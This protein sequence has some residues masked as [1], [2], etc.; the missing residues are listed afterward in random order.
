MFGI[1]NRFRKKAVVLMYHKIAEPQT[2]PWELAV[3]AQN[4]E[5]HSKKKK[6]KCKVVS[7]EELA[8]KVQRNKLGRRNVAITFDDAYLNNYTIAKPLLENYNLPA[9]FFI[10]DNNLVNQQPFWWDSLEQLIIH[11]PVLPQH[12]SVEFNAELIEF[13]LQEEAL[14]TDEL[15]KKH[16][17]FIAYEPNT[18]RS[19][20]YYKLW[21]FMSPL[22]KRD[23]DAFM[24]KIYSWAQVE[25]GSLEIEKCMTLDQLKDMAGNKL[26]TIGA[27]TQN[28]PALSY[29]SKQVQMA[30]VKNNKDFLET[31]LKQSVNYF[32]YPSG[33]YNATSLEV[34]QEL[35]FKA[36]F[37]TRP[38]NVKGKTDVYKLSRFQVYNWEEEKFERKLNQWFKL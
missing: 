35:N 25:E 9:A 29:H 4:F 36:A 12:F 33:N 17:R 13:D 23:Q 37:T 15:A 18:L 30:E 28:H 2:D 24:I 5:A 21:E 6:K 10:T 31:N 8:D 11:T 26:F 14:L 19:Q 38:T 27:H 22:E 3:S 1:R 16:H 34:M 20:L 32:A 7:I